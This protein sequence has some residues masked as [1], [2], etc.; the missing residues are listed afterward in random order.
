L[1]KAY[2]ELEYARGQFP[3]SEKLADEILSL[4]ISAHLLPAETSYVAQQLSTL[5]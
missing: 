2:A 3:I 4:P 5:I 1:Q